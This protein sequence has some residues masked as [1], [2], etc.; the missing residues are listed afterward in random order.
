MLIP[1]SRPDFGSEEKSA[2]IKIIN[3]GWLTQGKETKSFETELANYLGVKHVVC[4]NNGTSALIASLLANS[5]GPLDEVIAPTF[6]FIA[7]INSIIAIGAKPVL[8]DC[9][10]ET[11]CL[12]PAIV[13]KLITPKTKA[14]MP[15]AV[16]G[17]PVDIEGFRDLC[18]K[19]NLVLIE[20]SAEAFGAEYMGKKVGSF[21]HDS[22]FSFHM[23]K[24]ITTVEGGCVATNDSDV[25]G[26][27][28][29]IR[30]HGREELYQFKKQGTEFHFDR[31]GL[32]LRASD[33]LSAI[34]RV[35]LSKIDRFLSHRKKLVDFY[36][37]K[38]LGLYG[39]QAIPDYVTV[40]SNMFF[41]ILC[42]GE[43]RDYINEKLYKAQVSTRIWLPTHKQK[44][45]RKYFGEIKL[46]N[47][48]EL[49]SR[50]ID[51]PLGNKITLKEA[52]RVVEV[53]KNV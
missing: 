4:I 51:I 35:Q 41:G 49:S 2:A 6:T 48:E 52:S 15:V 10:K 32:N 11:W 53:L 25:A 38:L 31:F 5:I 18:K 46:K 7:T 13:E 34:G 40:H 43:K 20:D 24:V 33:V 44:W 23:A 27:I 36:K 26:K 47:A 19:Y 3:S 17:M 39:F 50:I 9:D 14:V 12:T 37:S 45:H 42:D 8:A 22:I 30:N 16:A 28:R 29:A 1:W 21:G